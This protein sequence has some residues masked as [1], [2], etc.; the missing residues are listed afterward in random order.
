MCSPR[1]WGALRS[2][3]YVGMGRTRAASCRPLSPVR[4]PP[5]PRDPS[6]RRPGRIKERQI[7]EKDSVAND[8]LVRFARRRAR[9]DRGFLVRFNFEGPTAYE[10]QMAVGLWFQLIT[11]N[12]RV[13]LGGA[14]PRDVDIC[15]FSPT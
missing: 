12:A 15:Q 9:V 11:Q 8:F 1:S 10:H 2:K 14:L 13:A 6:C 3:K 4:Q 5:I 7:A